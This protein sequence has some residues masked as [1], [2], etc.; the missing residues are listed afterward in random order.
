[1]S[2]AIQVK[3]R[4]RD[5]PRVRGERNLLSCT[6]RLVLL[7]LVLLLLQTSI[8]SASLVKNPLAPPDTS[9]P[10]ATM[11]SFAE[12]VNKAAPLLMGAYERY[13]Q[14]QRLFA[15]ISVREQ[16]EEGIILLKQ[17]NNCLNLSEVP[18]ALKRDRGVEGVILLK[19]IL[20]RIE[21]P[22][23]AEIPNAEA[24]AANDDLT[25]W[26]LPQTKI[27]IVKVESG[28]R[29]GEFLFSPET[30]TQLEEFYQKVK[31]L[32]H[33]SGATEGFFQFWFYTPGRLNFLI[34]YNFFP[35][36]P[37]WM[38]VV[39]GKQA[40]WQWIGLG[41]CLFVTFWIPYQSFH[42]Q[43]GRAN[44]FE[45][46]EPTWS[47]LWPFIITLGS[48]AVGTFFIDFWLNIGRELLLN[49]L[50]A[51]DILFWIV[52][53]ITIFHFGNALAETIIASTL[54]RS[55]SLNASAIRT[56]FRL[57][58]LIIGTIILIL[59]FE[60]VGISLFPILAGLGFGGSGTGTSKQTDPRKYYCWT[61]LIC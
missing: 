47:K 30:V 38:K 7:A 36:L 19:E 34:P 59:E 13:L 53:T 29:V 55:R 56:F 15:S 54:V 32:P 12:N 58:S 22:P 16:I 31:T 20:A 2:K 43:W 9:S 57:L 17:A 40:L 46:P 6:L 10:Q 37:S 49:L 26:R 41:F 8:T 61:A 50:T 24:V 1:M 5:I 18:P 11:R 33:K 28:S 21:V 25:R 60:D 3:Q 51:L 35:L 27:D 14:E 48:L 52:A 23:Y 45:S 4:S 44:R 42:S 39:Y